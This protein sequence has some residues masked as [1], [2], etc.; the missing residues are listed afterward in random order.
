MKD[1]REGIATTKGKDEYDN[2]SERRHSNLHRYEF[3]LHFL[4]SYPV[5]PSSDVLEFLDDHRNEI[6][7]V[8]YMLEQNKM[9]ERSEATASRWMR[10]I[11]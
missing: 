8:T 9:K 2:W 1:Q 7:V 10:T 11:S 4:L 5:Q 3:V 6:A